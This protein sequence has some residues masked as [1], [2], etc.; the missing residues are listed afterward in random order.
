MLK[1]DRAGESERSFTL[2]ATYVDVSLC[3]CI[4]Q[5]IFA[6]SQFYPAAFQSTRREVMKAEGHF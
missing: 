2:I 1:Y 5:D 6:R 3:V 4:R